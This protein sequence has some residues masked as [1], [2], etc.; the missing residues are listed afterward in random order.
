M[1]VKIRIWVSHHAIALIGQPHIPVNIGL[2]LFFIAM[3][4]SIQFDDQKK[5]GDIEINDI[6]ANDMLTFDRI[7]QLLQKVIP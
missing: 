6:R 5:S 7:G 3:L 4:T 2:E 1:V